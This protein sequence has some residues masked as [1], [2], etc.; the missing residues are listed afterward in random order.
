MDRPIS[1]ITF[2]KNKN[3]KKF[4][5]KLFKFFLLP[6][7]L[8]GFIVS[9]YQIYQ[10]QASI[11]FYF[12]KNKYQKLAKEQKAIQEELFAQDKINQ[13]KIDALRKKYYDLIEEYPN[14]PLLFYYLGALNFTLFERQ[15]RK[16]DFLLPDTILSHFLNNH[17][18]T[19]LSKQKEWQNAVIYFRKALA[20]K[21]P[22]EQSM[23]I[24]CRLAYLYLFGQKAHLEVVQG[25]LEQKYSDLKENYYYE[26]AKVVVSDQKP[27]WE[28]L[29]QVL[30]ESFFT[31]LK[32]LH[33]IRIGNRPQGFFLLN[34]ITAISNASPKTRVY[35]DNALYLMGY[36]N[37]NQNKPSTRQIYYYSLIKL[38]DFMQRHPWFFE[39]YLFSLRFFGRKQK[40]K[41]VLNIY[42]KLFPGAKNE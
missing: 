10:K 40:I 5:N 26:I 1:K 30:S 42:N 37:K 23:N 28:Y 6:L 20:L 19:D 35:I 39:E 34:R 41:D 25:F 36:L 7:I 33:A 3:R 8:I 16:S 13:K 15:I 18:I 31:Y 17:K 14:E 27:N 32:G 24:I 21:L 29:G 22:P 4:R 9:A 12:Q 38:D 11:I 2:Y